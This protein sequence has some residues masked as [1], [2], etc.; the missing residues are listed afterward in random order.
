VIDYQRFTVDLTEATKLALAELASQ[1]PD[2]TVLVFGYETDD[3]VVVLTPVANTVE[4]HR[5]MVEGRIYDEGDQVDYL[6][7]QEWPL[8]AVGGKHFER[9]SQTV[10]QYVY[11]SPKDQVAEPFSDR[12]LNL[13]KAF[14]R[15]LQN[16]CGDRDGIFLAIFNPDPGLDTSF[17]EICALFS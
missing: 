2:E 16:A 8:Y 1:R 5:R 11:E 6:M 17:P 9:V 4:E 14:G 15:A 7:I 3:D 12:K 13:L 10:N